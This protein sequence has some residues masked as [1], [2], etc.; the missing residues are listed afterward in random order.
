M[1]PCPCGYLYEPGRCRCSAPRILRYQSRISGPLL[2]RLDIH[3]RTHS[4][5][6]AQLRRT[7]LHPESTATVAARVAA[8]HALQLDR[9]RVCN[10]QLDVSAVE[11]F[12]TSTPDA[13]QIL[14]HALKRF[15][16]SA[17][18]YYRILK[19]ARTLADLESSNQITATHLSEALLFKP[20]DPANSPSTPA[21][22][23]A[24]VSLLKQRPLH[25]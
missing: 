20:L 4:I 5:D 22:R 23:T 7:D 3:V 21:R 2:D 8:A 24:S 25:K 6:P 13:Q 19:V 16:L 11:R 9:Q 12:C 18:A 15:R 17:R 1:N 14:E 10:A